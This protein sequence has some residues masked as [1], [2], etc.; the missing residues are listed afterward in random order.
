[1]EA[2]EYLKARGCD[3]VIPACTGMSTLGIAKDIE[4]I[5]GLKVIDPIMASGVCIRYLVDKAIIKQ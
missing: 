3:T 1:M 5:Y 4:V 2:A